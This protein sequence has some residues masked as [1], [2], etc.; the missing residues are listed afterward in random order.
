MANEAFVHGFDIGYGRADDERLHARA[1]ADQEH[2]QKITDLVNQR[3]ELVN[4]IPSLNQGTPEYDEAHKALQAVNLNLADVYHPEKNPGAIQKFGHLLTDH[5]GLT[6]PQDRAAKQAAQLQLKT[7]TAGKAADAQIAAAPPTPAQLNTQKQQAELK[8][9]DASN[10][11]EESKKAARAKVFGVVT[12]VKPN[13]Q[14]YKNPDGTISY[15][16]VNKP[17]D[18][19]DGASAVPKGAVTAAKETIEEWQQETKDGKTTLA[20]PAWLA[21]KRREG[22]PST[23]AINEGREDYSKSHGYKAWSDIPDE[24]R[25]VAMNYMLR[26]QAMDKAYP[27]STTTTALKLDSAGLFRPVTETNYKTPEGTQSLKDPL[28]FLAAPAPSPNDGVKKPGTTSGK[29]PSSSPKDL[30]K[31]ADTLNPK[32]TGNGSSKPAASGTSKSG[33]ASNTKVGDPLFAGPNKELT[34][35][36]TAY[37]AAVHRKNLMHKNLAEGLQ[38]NQQAM[39]SLVANHIGMTLGAQKGARINQAVWNEAVESAPWLKKVEAKF[40]PDG[41]LSGVTLAPEQMKQ[42]VQLADESTEVTK[43]D[44]DRIQARLDEGVSNPSKPGGA[45]GEKKNDSPPKAT[46]PAP[47][48]ATH[49]IKHGD[50][51]YYTDDLGNNLGEI[52]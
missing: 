43:D 10:L 6:N 3:Q 41:Y 27:V 7:D 40:G 51:W 30:K 34:D 36:K 38:G 24:Y 18:I 1:L 12:S 14:Q 5:I 4:K 11:D 9:I 37:D 25:D 42:M 35:A 47:P 19:P 8:E 22:A 49:R 28:W 16:D 33:G 32:N 44:V 23:S 20:Y 2:Q 52:T 26:K 39:L 46:K 48:K 17:D 13:F 45:G 21:A 29:T 50:K 31:E 15:Y